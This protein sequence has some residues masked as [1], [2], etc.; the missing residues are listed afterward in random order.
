MNQ[1]V[2][3]PIFFFGRKCYLHDIVSVVEVNH[4]IPSLDG[5]SCLSETDNKYVCGIILTIA[6]T[7]REW[8]KA[9]VRL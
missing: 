7:P 5:G 6:A 1:K 2:M 9:V 4:V 3:F 8:S